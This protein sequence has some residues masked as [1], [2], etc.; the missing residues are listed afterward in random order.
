MPQPAWGAPV[1]WGAVQGWFGQV[2]IFDG[3]VGL[4][5]IFP[6]E[7]PPD[8]GV[9]DAGGVLYGLPSGTDSVVAC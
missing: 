2:T 7:P 1:A 9:C 4:R 5:D 8:F 6:D 3:E